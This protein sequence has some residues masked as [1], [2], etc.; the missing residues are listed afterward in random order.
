[1]R[2]SAREKG[3]A[4]PIIENDD[5]LTMLV[6]RLQYYGMGMERR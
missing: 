5:I 6:K 4:Q 3:I 2:I 1:M